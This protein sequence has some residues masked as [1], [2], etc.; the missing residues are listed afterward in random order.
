[1][2]MVNYNRSSDSSVDIAIGYGLDG[3][4]FNPGRDKAEK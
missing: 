4:G 3:R 2:V 1:M